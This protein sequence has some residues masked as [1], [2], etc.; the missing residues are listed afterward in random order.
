MKVQ[1]CLGLEKEPRRSLRM[2]NRRLVRANVG[3][4]EI[5]GAR[6]VDPKV[7]A[8]VSASSAFGVAGWWRQDPSTDG[9]LLS[10]V[11]RFEGIRYSP[12]TAMI[13]VARL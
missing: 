8:A 11:Q 4:N 1:P 7:A 10:I 9:V 5:E 6:H 12:S 2:N 3:S 13:E